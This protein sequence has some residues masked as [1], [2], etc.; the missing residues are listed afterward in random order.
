MGSRHLRVETPVHYCRLLGAVGS[1]S[2][3]LCRDVLSGG[4][5]WGSGF[6]WD[7]LAGGAVGLSAPEGAPIITRCRLHR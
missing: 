2:V 3:S 7:A 4:V 6:R 5:A 1:E